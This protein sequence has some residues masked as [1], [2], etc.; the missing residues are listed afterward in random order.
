[1]DRIMVTP[2]ATAKSKKAGFILV[3]TLLPVASLDE[4]LADLDESRRDR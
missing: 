2:G 4:V 1:M 3:K